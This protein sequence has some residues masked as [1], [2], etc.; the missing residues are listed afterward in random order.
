LDCVVADAVM[1]EPVLAARS[2]LAWN[3]IGILRLLGRI[4][5]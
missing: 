5:N 2:L 1:V 3:R 4:P